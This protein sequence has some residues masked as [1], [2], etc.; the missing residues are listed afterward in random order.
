C[1]RKAETHHL[2]EK[3]SSFGGG[4]AQVG[5][6]QLGHLVTDA[7]PRQWEVG[8]LTGGDHQMQLGW[9]VFKQK[10]ECRVNRQ[11][12]KQV[13]V[14]KDEDKMVRERGDVVEQGRQDRFGWRW[15]R[16]LE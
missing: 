16:R 3:S 12:I 8:I 13:V 14:V 1:G 5:R 6:A 2:R 4:K 7:E 10:G 11:S 15:L 9:Q